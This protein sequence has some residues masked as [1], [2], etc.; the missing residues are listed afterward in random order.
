M[1]NYFTAIDLTKGFNQ[2][3]LKKSSSELAAFSAHR[4]HYQFKGLSFGLKNC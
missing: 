2:V 3:S 1:E 4:G